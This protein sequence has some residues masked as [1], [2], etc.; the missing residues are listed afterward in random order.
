MKRHLTAAAIWLLDVPSRTT[1]LRIATVWGV[2]GALADRP[3]MVLVAVAALLI[4]AVLALHDIARQVPH[5]T[6]NGSTLI[7]SA[8]Q[9]AITIVSGGRAPQRPRL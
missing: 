9:P 2:L 5:V 6:I 7:G 1:W 4:S 8:D 3:H